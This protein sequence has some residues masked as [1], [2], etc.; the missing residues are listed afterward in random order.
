MGR[1]E[2]Q[3]F[4]LVDGR[5]HYLDKPVPDEIYA[6]RRILLAAHVIPRQNKRG[7]YEALWLC[8]ASQSESFVAPCKFIKSMN[9]ATLEQLTNFKF[10]QSHALAAGV[11]FTDRWG[12]SLEFIERYQGGVKRLAE[13]YLRNPHD[14]RLRLK[15]EV[16]W[17]GM[18]TASFWY[19]CMDGTKLMTLDRHNFKQ[20][21]GIGV[22]MKVEY[23]VPKKRSTTGRS[24]VVS[25]SVKEYC[26]IENETLELLKNEPEVHDDNKVNSAF[27]TALFWKTGVQF[28]RGR[29]PAQIDLFD[30]VV[31]IGF[32]S[33]YSRKDD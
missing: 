30:K 31:P 2:D 19:L 32:L 5:L 15:K 7:L 21:N 26:R 6:D 29:H 3:F 11:L 14:I 27:I 17:L 10:L 23:F 28:S 8:L 9:D 13:D 24:A 12:E 4:S 20:I 33:P 18:K 25:A 16:R 22:D 1:R